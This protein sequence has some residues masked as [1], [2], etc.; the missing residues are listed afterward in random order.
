MVSLALPRSPLVW[1][2]QVLPPGCVVDVELEAKD[3]L[4]RLV[5]TAGDVAVA[6]Y[7]VLRTDLG[8]RDEVFRLVHDAPAHAAHIRLCHAAGSRES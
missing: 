8:R 5:G 1:S 7:R 6:G 4:S 3:L 2:F